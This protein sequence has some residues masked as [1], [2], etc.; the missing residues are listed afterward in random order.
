MK[1]Y[2]EGFIK[3]YIRS[4]KKRCDEKATGKLYA[5]AKKKEEVAIVGIYLALER[6]EHECYDGLKKPTAHFG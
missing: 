5:A 4:M 2:E 1:Y 3:D 6:P